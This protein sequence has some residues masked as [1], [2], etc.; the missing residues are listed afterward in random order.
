MKKIIY[1]IILLAVLYSCKSISNSETISSDTIYEY[2]IV[3]T[4][5]SNSDRKVK[6]YRFPYFDQKLNLN[7]YEDFFNKILINKLNK[8]DY[9]E[10]LNKKDSILA[11]REISESKKDSL[12]KSLNN[13]VRISVDSFLTEQDLKQMVEQ[14]Q[15]NGYENAKWVKALIENAKITREK[16]ESIMISRPVFNIN[17]DIAMIFVVYSAGKE[18]IFYK[19]TSNN[20]WEFFVSA[21]ISIS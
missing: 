15:K 8:K 2:D 18:V 16:K 4:Y 21:T 6:L 5:L 1:F 3:N 19:K 20:K 13:K 7:I 12:I 17:Y 9:R 10:I 11:S 14:F